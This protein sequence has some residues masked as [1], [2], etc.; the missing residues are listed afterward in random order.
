[1]VAETLHLSDNFKFLVKVNL[2]LAEL[3]GRAES[4]ALE[5]PNTSMLKARQLGELLAQST[6]AKFGITV[7]SRRTDQRSLIDDLYRKRLLP[8]EVKSLFCLLYTSPSP[9]DLS[10]SRM[11]SSA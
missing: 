7:D 4:Y 3:G 10:T 5:D 6:A 8:S 1:M 11:P 9:R 2:L